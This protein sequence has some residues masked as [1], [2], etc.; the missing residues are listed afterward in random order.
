MFKDKTVLISG[1]SGFLASYIIDTFLYLNQQQNLNIKIIG[2]Q[3][4]FSTRVSNKTLKLI[5]ED[6][7]NEIR[8][9]EDIDYIIHT[10]GLATPKVFNENPVGVVL[11]NTLGTINLLNLAIEKKVKGFLFF[12]TTGVYGELNKVQ[13]PAHENSFNGYLDPTD[14]SS[15]YLESKRMGENL[16]IAW[17]HQYGVPIKI[18]R[19][20]IVYGYGIKLNDGRSFADFISNIINKQ[21]IVLFSEGK[22]LRSFCYVADAIVGFFIVLLKGKVGEAYNI[23]P[24]SEISIIDL[25]NLLIKKVFPELKLKVVIKKDDSKTYLRKEFPCTAMDTR[26]LKELGWNPNFSLEEGFKRTI[27]S[28][29]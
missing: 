29:L 16:C 13:Y 1:S 8:I 3:R 28:Y 11:P 20:S 6:I 15:C 24:D 23:A 14:V 10:A 12:S 19:P 5:Y 21:D 17:M 22:A 7:C 2:I 4:N 26:K 18:V 27:E 25:A 9:T